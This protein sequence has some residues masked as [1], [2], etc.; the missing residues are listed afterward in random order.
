MVK[1]NKKEKVCKN[2]IFW[3]VGLSNDGE[4]RINPPI[5]HDPDLSSGVWV[6]TFKLDWCGQFEGHK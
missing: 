4:C 1:K 2:C 3:K 5:L 6:S